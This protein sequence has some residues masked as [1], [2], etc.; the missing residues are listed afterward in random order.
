MTK[1]YF[2]F[3]YINILLYCTIFFKKRT[4][5]IRYKNQQG[6]LSKS[7]F[8]D[9]TPPIPPPYCDI[10][11]FLRA[12][13]LIFPRPQ[14]PRCQPSVL[15]AKN[16]TKN[17]VKD[18]TFNYKINNYYRHNQ[19]GYLGSHA[20][21][22]RYLFYIYKKYYQFPKSSLLSTPHAPPAV[23]KQSL[24]KREILQ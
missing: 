9:K 17:S 11:L 18:I 5:N 13:I 23:L 10:A 22:R 1:F 2:V 16:S 14:V 6:G 21:Q 8:I 15:F 12:I 19:H 24:Y 4:L 7:F 20:Q 3:F